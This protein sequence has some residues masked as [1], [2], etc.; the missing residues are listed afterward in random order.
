MAKAG[1]GFNFLWVIDFEHEKCLHHGAFIRYFNFAPELIAQGHTVTFAVNFLDPNRGPSIEYFQR[2]KAQ[3]IITDFLEANFEAPAWRFR[4]AAW[5]F[6]PGIV[7]LVLQ[8]AQRRLAARID[9]IAKE[10]SSN[11][12]LI[13]G[14]RSLFLPR[15]SK[16]GCA[17]IYDL[18]DCQTLYARRQLG[19]RM[20]ERDWPGLMRAVKPAV[21]SYAR[22]RYYARMPVMKMMV[23]PVDKQAIDDISGNPHTSTV[24]LNGVRDGAARG[25]H[26]KVPGRIIFTG[27]MDFPPNSDAALWFLEHVFPLVLKDRPDACFVVAGANPIPAL[28]QRA[29]KSVIVT[30]FVE[31]L[32]RE[33]AR[34]EI[35]VAPLVSGGGFKN[36]VLEAIANRTSVVAT[37]IAVEFVDP[38]VRS[39]IPVADSPADMAGAIL[40]I[41][42]HPREAEARAEELHEV[43]MAQF[44]WTSRAAELAELARKT[45]AQSGGSR[46]P[47]NPASDV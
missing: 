22:E 20:K 39:L 26:A 1:Q 38:A 18:G 17:F 13:S 28:R 45:I 8:S 10:R 34:S 37:S 33:I 16:S 27:N 32:N 4:A 30:G 5:L 2:L 46:L 12:I 35:C 23:S 31:D 24:I 19:V 25:Q 36:K 40:A 11:V 44:S 43:A 6:H 14:T 29:S 9:E 15:R 21:Y 3:G 47:L 7:N 42:R 41:W